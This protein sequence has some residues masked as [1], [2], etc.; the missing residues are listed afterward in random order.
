L[1]FYSR[2]QRF[3]QLPVENISVMVGRVTF[4][5]FA[6][7]QDDKPRLKRGI[8]KALNMLVMIN[9]P[10]M[11]GMAVVA[12]PMILL[13]LT[14]KWAPCV[15]Y[16]QLLCV[17]GM[18]YPLHL[19]NLNVLIAQGRSDLFFRLEVLKKIVVVIA[20]AVTY[21]WGIITM[22]YGQIATSFIAF[23]LNAY[24]TGKMLDY[25]ISQQIQDLA[26][27]LVL[28]LMMGF[29]IYAL[30]YTAIINPLVLFITQIM[31]GI[32]LYAGA[33]YIFRIASFLEIIEMIKSKLPN[34]GYAD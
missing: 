22:I 15:P 13:L 25:P 30:N 32:I 24:Y 23:Y 6:S 10:M 20:I 27:S 21:R 26:P 8:R 5:V 3:Q 7:V 4:P 28:S 17:V 31:T 29:G 33:C 16:L 2:A 1:G 11:V 34:P 18:L 12:K 19:I 14:E 9:F